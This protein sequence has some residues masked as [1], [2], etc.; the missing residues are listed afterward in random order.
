MVCR[1]LMF[2]WSFRALDRGSGHDRVRAASGR[3][4]TAKWF[5]RSLKPE[6]TP[7]DAAVAP[8]Y[9]RWTD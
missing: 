4:A 3:V 2:M 1:I 9:G 8:V 7:E 5:R 6:G